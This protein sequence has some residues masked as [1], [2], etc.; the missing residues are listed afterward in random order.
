M[1]L[2]VI[3]LGAVLSAHSLI[4]STSSWVSCS[5]ARSLSL[6]VRGLSCAATSCVLEEYL[7]AYLDG[8][9][10]RDDHITCRQRDKLVDFSARS[11]PDRGRGAQRSAQ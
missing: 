7:T 11:C 9:G 3:E 8:A 2:R 5:F 1:A 10:L 6:V 4:L